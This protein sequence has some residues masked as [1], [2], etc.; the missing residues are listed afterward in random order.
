MSSKTREERA[1]EIFDQVVEI[2]EEE[3][4]RHLHDLCGSDRAL[5][6]RVEQLLDSDDEGAALFSLQDSSD[7]AKGRPTPESRFGRFRLRGLLGEGGMGV[8]YLAEQDHPKREVALKLL[9]DGGLSPSSRAR[10]GA[11]VDMHAKLRHPGIAQIYEAGTEDT[12]HGPV[13]YFAME[14][15]RGTPLLD[16]ANLADLD[17]RG[18]LKLMAEITDAVEHA[19]RKGV[20][21][22]DIKPANIL[23][24]ED[25]SPKILDFGIGRSLDPEIEIRHTRTGQIIG[26]LP[27]MSP[28]QCR[29][30]RSKVDTTSDVYSLAVVTY[31]LLSGRQP[32]DL[33]DLGFD[34]AIRLIRYQDP[35][36]LGT[37]H[38]IWRGDIEAIVAKGLAK[39]PRRRYATAAAF[40]ADL[41]RFLNDE[42][43]SAVLPTRRY[44]LRKFVSRYRGAV[45]AV[46]TIFFLLVGALAVTLSLYA[47]R[48]R[49]IRERRSTR[50]FLEWMI[51][52]ADP[53]VHGQDLP[54]RE[55]LMIASESISERFTGSDPSEAS[56]RAVIGKTLDSLAAYDGAAA[57]LERALEIRRD[58]GLGDRIESVAL[59]RQLAHAYFAP[60][61]VSE[62]ESILRRLLERGT[63]IHGS[64]HPEILRVAYDLAYLLCNDQ[65]GTDEPIGL[66]RETLAR[67]ERVLG[68]E[69]G[70]T[71][72]TKAQLATILGIALGEHDSAI[73]LTIEVVDAARK[74]PEVDEIDTASYEAK[75]ARLIGQARPAE[76][77][78]LYT[79]IVERRKRTFGPAHLATAAARLNL[80]AFL[81]NSGQH[82]EAEEAY[83]ASLPVLYENLGTDHPHV[84]LALSN[85]D[86]LLG[87]TATPEVRRAFRREWN[88]RLESA[89]YS[90]S[91]VVPLAEIQSPVPDVKGHFGST[92]ATDG[93]TLIVGAPFEDRGARDSGVV[94]V[95][96]RS[97]SR[98]LAATPLEPTQPEEGLF[99]GRA[100]ALAG[101]RIAVTSRSGEA[102]GYC[103]HVYCPTE[104]GGWALEGTIDPPDIADSKQ[105]GSFVTADENRIVIGQPGSGL[106][107]RRE[108]G[109]AHVFVRQGQDWVFEGSLVPG[110]SAQGDSFGSCVSIDRDRIVVGAQGHDGPAENTGRAYVFE[111]RDGRWERVRVLYPPDAT[112]GLGFGV[113]ASVFG[114]RVLIGASGDRTQGSRS[115]A[116]YL[117]DLNQPELPPQKL[118]AS[119]GVQSDGFGSRVALVHNVALVLAPKD[120][121]AGLESGAIYVFRPYD[122]GWREHSKLIVVDADWKAGTGSIAI[123][124][125]TVVSGANHVDAGALDAGAVYVYSLV[126]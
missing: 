16:Y 74:N 40:A 10:F 2:S 23:V 44:R 18:K 98:W 125:E 83:R 62:A 124:G 31:E 81:T 60:G 25:G 48:E 107:A 109:I 4:R 112:D 17:T 46:A 34:E 55:M 9:R 68:V 90:H 11:E 110:E 111:L 33:D 108:G 27:Y 87:S 43:V 126:E 15:V 47:S 117:Y 51:G 78:E 79:S 96:R 115:G 5:R 49:E 12:E 73:A 76:A 69:H 1:R 56:L 120:N 85:F 103:V 95:Y 13:P 67:Q 114:S 93:A 84:R 116:A 80:A 122:R 77:A 105:F 32:L 41:R 71:I 38:R 57:Q 89:P 92:V 104:A 102:D 75:L 52:A 3:R 100:V 58:L 22:R 42:P 72:R 21:H 30:S 99:F 59:E 37:I 45:V 26:T 8:V 97:E 86:G 35:P 19:H 28:E 123:A 53:R 7:Q 39:E 63:R 82:N 54:L 119:D 118:L 6:A 94:Y 70:D 113:S 50:D 24:R 20:L 14:A 64:D 65:R 106:P 36:L 91:E 66:L 101:N 29:G 88:A 121:H 61:R